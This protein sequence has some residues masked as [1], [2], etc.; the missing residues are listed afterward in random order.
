MTREEWR[1]HMAWDSVDGLLNFVETHYELLDLEDY[2]MASI[3]ET[4][5]ELGERIARLL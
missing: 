4:L 3:V 5:A 1:L 2:Q